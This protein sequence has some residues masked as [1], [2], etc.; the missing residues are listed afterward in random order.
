[1]LVRKGTS[2]LR[3]V[4]PDASQTHPSFYDPQGD[5]VAPIIRDGEGSHGQA[6]EA[7]LAEHKKHLANLQVR[8]PAECYETR[9]D[10]TGYY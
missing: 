4:S 5:A 2:L 1:M 10:I 8:N 7:A 3:R 6:L 9:E